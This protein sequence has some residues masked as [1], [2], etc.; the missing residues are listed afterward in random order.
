MDENGLRKSEAVPVL[1]VRN[2]AK[3]LDQVLTLRF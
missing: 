2:N 3:S 1:S